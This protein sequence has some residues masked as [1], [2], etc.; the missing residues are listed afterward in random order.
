MVATSFFLFLSLLSL[1]S[2]ISIPS[3]ATITDALQG[4]VDTT[5][6]N[7]IQQSFPSN[8]T[9]RSLFIPVPSF[10]L[11]VRMDLQ[12]NGRVNVG[13]GPFGQRNWVPIV[14]GTWAATWGNGTVYVSFPFSEP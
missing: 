1:S 14:G 9:A 6:L 10:E 5:A 3:N 12:I 4:Y 8:S 2:A 11:D 13:P 7:S